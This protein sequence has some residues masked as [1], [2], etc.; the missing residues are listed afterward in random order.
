MGAGFLA[1]GTSLGGIAAVPGA[2]ALLG[3]TARTGA[4]TIDPRK[5]SPHSPAGTGPGDRPLERVEGERAADA[6]A[7][8]AGRRTGEETDMSIH[9]QEQ[10]DDTIVKAAIHPAIGIARV[11]S[12]TR[13]DGWFYGPEV[14][15]PPPPAPSSLRDE[16][17]GAL[18]RQAARFRVYGLDAR[19][20]IVREL[21]AA[22]IDVDIAWTV[23][24]ANTKAA[25]Y[26][27]QLALD[28]PEA[29][30]PGVDPT[31][32]RN[33]MTTDR[34]A[35]AI[36]P[37][38][39]SVSGIQHPEV[40]FDDG[41]FMGEPVYLGSAWTDEAGRL[42]VLGGH[43]KAAS[44]DGRIALTYANNDG[45]HDDTSDGPVTA[46][47]S[48]GGRELPVEPAWVVVAPPNYGP[49]RKSVRTMWDLMRDLAVREGWL[50]RPA[51]PSFSTDILPIFERLA[52]LQWVNQGFAAGFG[53]KGLFDLTP[54]VRA[55]LASRSTADE[56]WRKALANR[57]RASPTDKAQAAQADST[58][59]EPWPWI[60]GDAMNEPPALS[61]RQHTSLTDLQHR[62]LAQW[63][64]GEFD[65]DS[66]AAPAR[67]LEDVPITDQ[68]DMLTRA[69][70]DFCLADAFHPGCEMTWPVRQASMYRAPFRFSHAPDGWIAPDLGPTLSFETASAAHGCLGPQPAGGITRWMAVPWQCDTASCG[71]GYHTDYDPYLPTFWPARVPNQVLSLADYGIV[72]DQA[73]DP[74][75]REEAFARRV[76]WNEP[77]DPRAP[78]SHQINT[79]ITRFD[80]LSV[81]EQRPGPSDGLFPAV[82]EVADAPHAVP[83]APHAGAMAMAAPHAGAAAGDV[84][85][86]SGIDK[87][88]RLPPSLHR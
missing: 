78:Y 37:Q 69:A 76:A 87:V 39:R 30:T 25:W 49:C 52:G 8:T 16:D 77:L 17:S 31:T 85:D 41:R 60:Y 66:A 61:P 81:V 57:F 26:G 83:G 73:N 50:K 11:G 32:P 44:H 12:S 72:V 14:T 65:D 75:L 68:G 7:A 24:L 15:D 10:R 6:A 48:L 63:A 19:G 2:S 80:R 67:S 59:P 29:A 47:V 54:A 38:A 84:T 18:K 42:V 9:G 23:R 4:V 40:R 64:K 20:G 55:R 1:A 53:W 74:Q 70:L 62:M 28:I 22:D 45:W 86:L 43:G 27:F 58:S 56:A 36:T 51:R 5:R 3:M 21:T 33:P 82:M 13:A 71:S 88:R 79:M 46:R 34:A 35:L